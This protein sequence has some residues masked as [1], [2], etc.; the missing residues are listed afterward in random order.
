MMELPWWDNHSHGYQ[1]IQRRNGTQC[2]EAEGTDE[3]K[4]N[5]IYSTKYYSVTVLK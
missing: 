1:Q 2:W 5:I 4:D 3:D